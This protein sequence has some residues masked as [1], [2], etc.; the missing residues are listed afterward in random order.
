MFSNENDF[1]E[2]DFFSVF[3]CI[4]ENASKNILQCCV[5]D[6]A[7]GVEGDACVFGKWFIKKNFANHFPNFNN[8]LFGWGGFGPRDLDLSSGIWI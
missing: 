4:P 5:K 7:G 1:R 2:N 3:G 8:G 6:R